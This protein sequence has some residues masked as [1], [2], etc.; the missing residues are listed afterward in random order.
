MVFFEKIGNNSISIFWENNYLEVCGGGGPLDYRYTYWLYKDGILYLT[1]GPTLNVGEFWNDLP[2]GNYYVL[3]LVEYFDNIFSNQYQFCQIYDTRN[4]FSNIT[5]TAPPNFCIPSDAT[6]ISFSRLARFYNLPL[7]TILLSGPNNPSVSGSIFGN[8]V[9][10]LT[11][12]ISKTTPNAVSELR[13]SCGGVMDWND[14]IVIPSNPEF[15]IITVKTDN[16]GVTGNNSILLPIKGSSMLIDWGDGSTS[17]HTQPNDPNS[18]I[19]G[20]NV[21]KTYASPGTYQIK[22]SNSIKAISFKNSG[23]R[24]KLISIN[25]W[26]TAAWENFSSAFHGCENMTGNF[27]DTPNLSGVTSTASMFAICRLFNSPIGNWNTSTITSMTSM[28]DQAE[29]FNQPIGNWNVSNVT[30][31]GFMFS[32]AFEFNQPLNSWNVS[33]VE[34]MARMFNTIPKFNQPLG[35]WNVSKV[36]NMTGMFA[37]SQTIKNPFNQPI[38]NW[39][40][41]NVKEMEQMF[42]DSSFNQ[43]ISSWNVSKV[44]N[45]GV[46]FARSP[47]NQPIGNWNVGEVT[48]MR[49]MFLSTPFNQ[50]IGNWN[51]SKVADMGDMFQGA[52]SFNQNI[53]SWNVQN[54]TIMTNMFQGASQFNQNIG[55]WNV[56]KVVTM[57]SMFEGATAFNQPIG[58]WD[59]SK[60]TSMLRMFKDASAFN[61]NLSTWCVSLIPTK[62]TEFDSGATSWTLSKPIW[63]TCP[64]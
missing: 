18:T 46:M 12:T 13:G 11:G 27:I 15:F 2:P 32:Q 61:R 26:G 28:F 33:N 43:D 24:L 45:M 3:I 19:G 31:M 48:N 17:T 54:V 60:V 25:Q 35:N 56:G 22:I 34:N 9:L 52:S 23:D 1:T 53:G 21:Q 16:T 37:G 14:T 59:V 57:N 8:S 4:E 41:G 10:P 39:N 64:S 5:I 50:P 20:N 49:Q 7:S 40:V 36:K 42:V 29:I 51:V 30:G 58:T 6:N 47:F 62:P 44:N 63:G 38:G 55:S